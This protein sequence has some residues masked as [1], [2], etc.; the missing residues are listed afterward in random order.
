VGGSG[1]ALF[2]SKAATIALTHTVCGPL[3]KE[4]GLKLNSFIHFDFNL[5]SHNGHQL[6]KIVI[7][8]PELTS[9]QNRI[10]NFALQFQTILF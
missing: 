9:I 5:L 4:A 1:E 7:Q 3:Q 2:S 6:K 10:I 8:Q